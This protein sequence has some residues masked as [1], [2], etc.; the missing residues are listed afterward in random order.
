MSDSK[1]FDNHGPVKLGGIRKTEVD[2]MAMGSFSGISSHLSTRET[3]E[4]AESVE[5]GLPG[6]PKRDVVPESNQSSSSVS[7]SYQPESRPYSSIQATPMQTYERVSDK[8]LE[9]P[10]EPNISTSWS[11]TRSEPVVASGSFVH[12]RGL[13]IG[14][15]VIKSGVFIGPF[16]A[17]RGDEEEPIVI[18]E[19]SS[20]LEGAI[21]NALPTRRD[22]QKLSQRLIQ[23]GSMEYPIFISQ[24][25]TISQ[26]VKIH[27]PAFV[28]A[29]TFVGMG[30]LIFWAKIGSNCVIE[31]GALIIN[32]DIPD[33]KFVPAGLSV[34]SQKMVQSLPAITSRYRFAEINDEMTRENAEILKGY[35]ER[36]NQR[37]L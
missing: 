4:A 15:V 36:S 26:G 3:T 2:K 32:V 18:S 20:V 31:P 6:K 19:N 10:F 5:Q 22:G 8:R 17:I 29:N 35:L 13:V 34:T 27:G 24:K 25:V 12:S 28:G 1:L 30:S 16:V 11:P 14:S 23:V 9:S 33:G 7:T 21:I 37:R